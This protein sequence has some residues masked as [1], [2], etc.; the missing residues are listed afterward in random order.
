MT[1]HA[2]PPRPPQPASHETAMRATAPATT[3]TP[4]EHFSVTRRGLITAIGNAIQFARLSNRSV[5]L[6]MVQLVRPDKLEAVVGIPTLEV[7]KHALR[8][9]PG[10]LRAVDRALA[11]SEDKIVILLPNLK[12]SAQ[13][14]L[15]AGKVQ[16]TLEEGFTVDG[17]MVKVRPV[18]GIA[19]YP[20][21]AEL[22]EELI[23]HSDIAVGIASHR[24]LAQHVFQAEDRRDSDIYL[25]LEAALREAVRTN[26]LEL[27]FQPQIDITTGKAASAEA[28]LRWR[29]PD[30][31]MVPPSTIVR[32]AEASGI[33]SSLNTWVI[34]CALRQQ[35]DWLKRGILIKLSLNLST[36]SMADGDL[37]ATVEQAMGTWNTDPS[38]ITFEITEGATVGD[39]V[40]SAEI[41]V[42]LKEQGAKL[43]IDD[44]GTGYSSL[45]YLKNL[46]LDELKIDKPFIQKLTSSAAEQKIV[47]FVI[48]L[49][50]DFGMKVVAEGV[51]DDATISELKK[52]GCDL[53]QGYAYSP[54]LPAADFIDWFQKH[55]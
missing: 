1:D 20:E 51:E 26:Q 29:A 38:T 47:K 16:Q 14:L 45:S 30:F 36:L 34:N 22:P 54:A 5:A 12:S 46:P 32:I 42:R 19:T 23:V 37:P 3:S 18:V 44:F 27:H 11:V 8:R 24:D 41:L 53:A 35:A 7:M 33:V 49:C 25:G 52:L 15:A 43:A 9:L 28:L 50:R 10:V 40:R 39:L 13:A 6:L 21:H 2:T 31:G 55:S 4:S 48:A 17:E